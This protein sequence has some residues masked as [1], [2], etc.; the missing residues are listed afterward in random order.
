MKTE[1]R[2]LYKCRMC[3]C[4]DSNT[5]T[6]GEIA[7]VAVAKAIINGVCSDFGIPVCRTSTHRCQSGAIGV[8]DLQG[9]AEYPVKE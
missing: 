6:G 4:L 1:W 9:A 2:I 7:Q 5:V 3:G 8:M